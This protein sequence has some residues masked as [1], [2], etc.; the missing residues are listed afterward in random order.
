MADNQNYEKVGK[1]VN[2]VRSLN[3]SVYQS[4]VPIFKE[5]DGENPN[6]T[7]LNYGTQILSNSIILNKFINVFQD[8]IL[9]ESFKMHMFDNEF[10]RRFKKESNPLRRA[11]FETFVNP[12]VPLPYDGEA[13]DRILKIYKRDVKKVTFVRNREDLF[14]VSINPEELQSAFQS[15]DAFWDFYTQ[16][17]TN[18]SNSNAIIEYNDIKQCFN[19]NFASGA[20]KYVNIHGMTTKEIN[21]LLKSTITKMSKPSSN[22]NNYINIEGAT[23]EPVITNT[24]KESI[25]FMPN[26]DL[27]AKLDTE[28]MASAYNLPYADVTRN[29]LDV[30]D[31]GYDVYDR[32]SQKI[33]RHENSKIVGILC[34]EYTLKFTEHLSKQGTTTNPAT[35]TEQTFWHV[36][37]TIALRPFCNCLVLIDD[38]D[39]PIPD[40]FALI[41]PENNII[42]FNNGSC[43][44][45]YRGTVPDDITSYIGNTIISVEGCSVENIQYTVTN[46]DEENKKITLSTD[47]YDGIY[48]NTGGSIGLLN[49]TT[50]KAVSA[51]GGVMTNIPVN[52]IESVRSVS[53]IE[54]IIPANPTTTT[55]L[56]NPDNVNPQ[57][58]CSESIALIKV[59]DSNSDSVDVTGTIENNVLTIPANT[60]TAGETYELYITIGE[61]IFYQSVSV[62]N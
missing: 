1:M 26:A 23:G 48:S 9:Y 24:P 58:I 18:L 42:E 15:M 57:V 20:L 55:I 33:L 16:Q 47:N 27:L 29:I 5:V 43:T 59:I 17:W 37:Q 56:M 52:Y 4:V 19:L 62:P 36:W 60:F 40:Y 25:V 8:V 11:V 45:D 21:T 41:T 46:I 51:T 50:F 3:D 53:Q 34:D 28:V 6:T 2:L 10:S 49:H 12:I 30:D 14:P 7:F 22:F 61:Q 54:E 31:F 35:L 39:E 32:E 44:L 13:L 38:G